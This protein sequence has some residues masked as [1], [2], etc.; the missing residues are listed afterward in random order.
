MI[1]RLALLTLGSTALAGFLVMGL[2]LT[3]YSAL[4]PDER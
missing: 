1:R 2:A 3:A 4:D